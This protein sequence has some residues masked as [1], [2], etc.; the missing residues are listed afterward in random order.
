[1][2]FNGFKTTRELFLKPF[3]M[4]DSFAP[5]NHIRAWERA[6]LGTAFLN[7][8]V[9]S[10]AGIFGV[11]FTSSMLAYVLS[12]YR[13]RF[14]RFIYVYIILGLALPAR[15]AIIPIFLLL[16]SLKLTD[17]RLGLVLVYIATGASFATFLLKNFMDG[18]PLEIEESARMDGASPWTVYRRIA[19]PLIKPALVVV[20]LVNFVNIWN[21]FFFPFIIITSKAK[22]TVPLAVS[23][24]YGEYSNQWPMIAAAL[25]IS[26]VPIMVVFFLF[27]KQFISGI[28]Q[29]AIK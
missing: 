27:S 19:L 17:T 1:M 4:P 7:S 26:V 6:G 15:L 14:R 23:L 16:N 18:I 29:G 22:E 2:F 11:L 25:T 20:G 3:E 24:F 5:E 13:F 10:G 21:D 28:T 8:I 9:V 12:R